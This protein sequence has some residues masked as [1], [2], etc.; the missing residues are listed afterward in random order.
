MGVFSR[1]VSTL[2]SYLS[3]D[4]T[5]GI[6][7]PQYSPYSIDYQ[8][9]SETYFK[10]D[11]SGNYIET[12]GSL[13]LLKIY[14]ANTCYLLYSLLVEVLELGMHFVMLFIQYHSGSE[15]LLFSI[16]F[17]KPVFHS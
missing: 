15:G 10:A 9:S 8:T 11:K 14:R 13:I 16:L 2:L 6:K 17:S 4:S 1:L 12:D 5:S 3:Y 7:A